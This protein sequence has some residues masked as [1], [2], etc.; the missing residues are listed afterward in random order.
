MI[1]CIKYTV[2]YNINYTKNTYI[3]IKYI[4]KLNIYLKYINI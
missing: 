1:L 2:E 3:Y 4:F